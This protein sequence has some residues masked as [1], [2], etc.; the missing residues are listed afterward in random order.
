MAEELTFHLADF[1][2]PLELLLTLAAKHKMDLHN[3]P[4]LE[5]IDQYTRT[6]EDAQAADPDIASSFIEMA[7][8]LVEMKS[9]LLLP[10]SEEG[11]RMKQELTGQLIEYD[12][13]RRMAGQLRAGAPEAPHFVRQTLRLEWDQTY[14]LYHAPQALAD[15]WQELMRRTALRRPPTQAQFEPLVAAP[16]VSVG[17]RVV[18]ILRRLLTGKMARMQQLFSRRQSRSTN[19][20]TFLA[21]L[22]LVRGGR[23]ELGPEGEMTV[24]RGHLERKKETT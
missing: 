13:C 10:R 17:S 18:F 22:E 4:I 16:Q 1:D 20:A 23:V 12:L 7:A 5:L 14:A 6:V 3:I 24:R 2:G 15:C 19:V 9:Y 21:L 11:E 8:H